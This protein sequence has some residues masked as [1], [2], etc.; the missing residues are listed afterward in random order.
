MFRIG[1]L[2]LP[3]VLASSVVLAEGPDPRVTHVATVAP[4][5]L[6]IT[7]ASQQ[8]R[9]GRQGPYRRAGDD[10]RSRPDKGGQGPVWVKR[11]GRPLGAL[12]GAKGDILWTFDRV[13]GRAL[14]TAW[15]DRA[16]SYTVTCRDDPNYASPRRPRAVH[17]KSKPTDMARIGP[18]QWGFSQ[19][20]VLYLVLPKPLTAGR[21]YTVRFRG[22]GLK[23]VSYTHDPS[24]T[25][26]EAVHVNHLGFRPSDPAKVAF[27]S[28]WM[29]SGG[30]LNYARGLTFHLLD[31]A[32][33]RKVLADRTKL[34]LAA[35]TPEDPYKRNYN[36]TDVH[37][38]DFSGLS[39]PGTYRVYVEGIGCS[40]PFEIGKDVYARAFRVA[41]RGFYHQRSGVELAP[42]HTTY[43]RP[44]CFHPDDGVKVYHSTCPI[45]DSA[46]GLNALG[47]DKNNFGNLVAGRTD[48]LVKNAWGGYQDA[49]DWDRRIQHLIASRYLI[50][51]AELFPEHFQAVDLNI[52]ESSDDLPDVINEALWN[53][54]CYRRMQTPEGGIRGGIESAEHPRAGECSW[55]ET[56]PVL[57]YAPGVWASYVYAGDAARAAT[58]LKSRKPK[59]AAVYRASAEAAMRFAER[60]YPKLAGKMKRS[61]EAVRDARNL[62]AMELLRCTG[63]PEWHKVFLAT[64]VFGDPAS[65]LYKWKHHDQGDAAFLYVRAIGPGLDETVR[66]NARK[67][68]LRSADESVR[69]VQATGFRWAKFNP[70]SPV[71]W[72]ALADPH[73]VS[74][75]RA[76]RL[77][78]ETKYLRSA[79]LA[80][81]TGLG[82]N[83]A[84][85][86]YTTGLGHESP[87][88]P[89]VVDSRTRGLAP[90]PGITV[91]GPTDVV[92][93]REHW[94]MKLMARATWPDPK[95]W[96][97]TEAYFDVYLF[98][99]VCEFTV[100]T[101]MTGV[102]YAWGYLSARP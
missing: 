41:A 95:D 5:V 14:D 49:G 92:R 77:T 24:R 10:V 8:T 99:Q 70:W 1:Q 17:R 51:L 81:Q 35:K 27:L 59:L 39:R 29:G 40:Y 62:A 64:T 3:V 98:P 90:P 93:N 43:R 80:C 20:H 7:V 60:G 91:F 23:D 45:M 79:V 13:V 28:C 88:N 32:T 68:I 36:R 61:A 47:T 86:C 21:T 54:D 16:E 55:Q 50:E 33:G 25:R 19:V 100:H 12:V 58:W 75:L 82:A 97:T 76:H 89:L 44:R 9:H 38:M 26:S 48:Q 57:A 83:P 11:G 46:N 56:L 34:A 53:L 4:D 102:A 52:P 2:V 96:P 30:K 63:K 87:K 66:A 37:E 42:P 22:G 65:D 31:H 71:G 84:N 67:A 73:A 101:T 94:A 78:G 18:W 6:G 69:M 72:G 74:L 15:A 85:L